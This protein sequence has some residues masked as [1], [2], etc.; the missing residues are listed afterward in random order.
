MLHLAFFLVDLGLSFGKLVFLIFGFPGLLVYLDHQFLTIL[1]LF[2]ELVV[3]D[4]KIFLKLVAVRL[5]FVQLRQTS[6]QF[7]DLRSNLVSLAV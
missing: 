1:R 2:A 7:L 3:K 4:S 6:C 5:C